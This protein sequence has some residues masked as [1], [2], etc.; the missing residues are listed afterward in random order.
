MEYQYWVYKLGWS[1]PKSDHR[2]K[3]LFYIYFEMQE[4]GGN[5]NG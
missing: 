4:C 1:L 5:K 2:L 3:E